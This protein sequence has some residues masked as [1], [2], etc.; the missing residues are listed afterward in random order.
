MPKDPTQTRLLI[1]PVIERA[2][3]LSGRVGAELPSHDGL[4]KATA[5]L[6]DAAQQ[7][8]RVAASMKRPWSPHRL[9]VVFLAVALLTVA[10]VLY[11]EF[12]YV[13]TLTLAL[14]DRDASLI[15]ENLKA[16]AR[17]NV[18][19]VDVP[20][21][22]E[23]AALLEKG[24][25]DLAFVQ[26]GVPISN[27]L[28]RLEI[29]SRELVLY[30]LRARVTGPSQVKKVL[31]SVQGEGSHSVAQ[32]FFAAWDVQVTYAHD[33]KRVTSEAGYVVP[34]D[35]DAVLVAKDP[36]DEA[37]LLGAERLVQQGFRLASPTLGARAGRYAW[38]QPASVPVGF[39][40]VDPPVP[41]EAVTTYSVATYL[42]AREGLTPR[43]L[44]QA[45]S[46]I[47]AKPRTID[48]HRFTLN[49]TEASELFQGVDAFFSIIVNIAL[50][51]LALLGLDVIA[52]RK[53]F[54][55]LNSLVSL[56]AMLQ[57]NKDVLGVPR[58]EQAEHLLY[59]SLCSDMLS[60]ISAISGYY[61]QENSSL[62]FNNLSELIHQRCDGLKLNIQLKL[63]HAM[64]PV[65][66]KRVS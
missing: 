65:E 34:D 27:E 59:L 61:T 6:V 55:G 56:I 24:S 62:L 1:G 35:I 36:G 9:P 51:F 37:A 5:M 19:V 60:I 15:R 3:L 13:S 26:G 18:K 42:V 14:P 4:H 25:V 21:S 46:V 17:V 30:F 49:S 63:L 57:S 54:H 12:F 38:L 32:A 22:R 33:W 45:A 39:L 43:L 28:A 64:V 29:P 53:Q 58:A 47:D 31:T 16:N 20:G 52:Y 41:A 66:G 44:A 23:G 7:A 11:R 10:G 8:Q 2:Q 40:H 48:E 50:A